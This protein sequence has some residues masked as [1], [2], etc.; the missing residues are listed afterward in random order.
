MGELARSLAHAPAIAFD[1][2]S[3]SLYHYSEKVCLL[4]LA[5]ASGD[6]VLVDPLGLIDLAPLG[7]AFS[8]PSAEKVVH[9]GEYDLTLLKRDFGFSFATL[10]DTQIAARFLGRSDFGLN[11]LLRD[12]FGL[13]LSKGSQKGD[14]SRRP[15]TPVME[16][17]A[18][19]DVRHLLPLRDR[20]R[21][22]LRK[23]RREAWVREE[24]EALTRTPAAIH[25][26]PADFFRV[27]G[28]RDLSPRELAVIRELFAVREKW[29]R[30][31][32]RP[33]FRVLTDEIILTLAQRRPKSLQGFP[34]FRSPFWRDRASEIVEAIRRAESLREAD[35]PRFPRR[36]GNRTPYETIQR[37]D[38]VRAWRSEAAPRIGLDPGVLLPQRLIDRIASDHPRN[39]DALAQVPELRRWRVEE[40]GSSILA[41]L[42]GGPSRNK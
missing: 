22:D 19:E 5:T 7:S 34:G 42:S 18:A 20:L 40:F 24:C 41:A 21:E 6:I 26:E 38:R 17:Y 39:L 10:F 29:A 3:D 15:L 4:Q 12:V 32:D 35:C 36:V 28:A 33:L 30:E 1:T 13:T 11:A 9:G 16:Q 37:I 27:K 14:W 25:R 2:E 8:S 31:L 23:S